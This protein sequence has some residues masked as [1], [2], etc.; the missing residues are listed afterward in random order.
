MLSGPQKEPSSSILDERPPLVYVSVFSPSPWSPQN[1]SWL[2]AAAA[3]VRCR[4]RQPDTPSR[5]TA[6]PV[7][8]CACPWA[9]AHN[10]A[11]YSPWLGAHTACLGQPWRPVVPGWGGRVRFAQPSRALGQALSRKHLG[12]PGTPEERT[13]FSR[14]LA[15]SAPT[16][17]ACRAP[18][19]H[20]PAAN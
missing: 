19:H 1:S 2:A 16:G 9:V 4:G 17:R 14:G 15:I 12:W 5:A 10:A 3:G 20:Q 7:P 18:W 8:S 11:L 6:H 13:T